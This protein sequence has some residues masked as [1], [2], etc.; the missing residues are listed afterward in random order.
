MR[1]QKLHDGQL[2]LGRPGTRRAPSVLLH[3]LSSQAEVRLR[4]HFLNVILPTG[5]ARVSG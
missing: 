5:S 3:V 4:N 2:P 1:R